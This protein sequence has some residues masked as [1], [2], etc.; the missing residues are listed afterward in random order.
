MRTRSNAL[1]LGFLLAALL[2]TIRLMTAK[3]AH[4]STTR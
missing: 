3:P 4:A 2:G 1:V